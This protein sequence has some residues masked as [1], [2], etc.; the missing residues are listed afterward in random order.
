MKIG[1]AGTSSMDSVNKPLENKTQKITRMDILRREENVKK[2]QE[3]LG[4]N[5]PITAI[6]RE[7]S[8]DF[9][10]LKLLIDTEKLQHSSKPGAPRKSKAHLPENVQKIKDLREKGYTL[11]AI[12]KIIGC[13]VDILYVVMRENNICG[14]T[15]T[16][17]DGDTY[18]QKEDIESKDEGK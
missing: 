8:Y 13:S 5:V 10:V 4:Q 16:S 9:Q 6:A 14:Y 15:N 18:S 1:I 2:I 7:F 11:K 3:L 17:Q 12:S